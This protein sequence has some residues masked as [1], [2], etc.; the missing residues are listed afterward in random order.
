MICRHGIRSR[1]TACAQGAAVDL[2][3][4]V[5]PKSRNFLLFQVLAFA[6][7]ILSNIVLHK[8]KTNT[9]IHASGELQRDFRINVHK[10]EYS[11]GKKTLFSGVVVQVSTSQ[12]ELIAY[13]HSSF[14]AICV[15]DV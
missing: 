9:Q 15:N 5:Q 12:L 1:H 10:C 6:V 14:S 4:C 3:F 8:Q 13:F 7:L 2:K 11:A